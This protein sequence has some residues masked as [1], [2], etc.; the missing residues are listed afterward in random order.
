MENVAFLGASSFPWPR[1]GGRIRPVAFVPCISEEDSGRQSKSNLGQVEL[2]KHILTLLRSQDPI[3]VPDNEISTRLRA[4]TVVLLTPYARQVTLLKQNIQLDSNTVVSTID[5]FQGREGDIVIFSTV[6]SNMSNDLG[7]TEDPRRLNVAWTRP[8]LG[9][10]VI[11][12]ERTLR[13]NAMWQRALDACTTVP[14][15]LPEIA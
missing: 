12:N 15:Q 11:G 5:G 14:V 7:F 10:I 2:A 4:L 6:R 3:G 8:K 9:L 1:A 13:S